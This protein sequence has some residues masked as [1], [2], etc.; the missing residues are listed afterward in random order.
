MSPLAARIDQKLPPAAAGSCLNK[1]LYDVIDKYPAWRGKVLDALA[2]NIISG[3]S[4]ENVLTMWALKPDLTKVNV[5]LCRAEIVRWSE[6]PAQQGWK[7]MNICGHYGTFADFIKALAECGFKE[8]CESICGEINEML[9]FYQLDFPFTESPKKENPAKER[10]EIERRVDEL[11]REVTK[12][13][14]QKK[15]DEAKL[16]LL[17]CTICMAKQRSIVVLPCTHFSF[18]E[19]CVPAVQKACY[20]CRTIITKHQPVKLS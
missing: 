7:L 9:F 6:I 10:S 18:C 19:T 13:K 2:G 4:W 17:E 1:K 8:L 5:E 12:L 11:E 15:E 3:T 20:I 14:K 16:D